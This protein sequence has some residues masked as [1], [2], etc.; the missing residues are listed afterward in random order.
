MQFLLYSPFLGVKSANSKKDPPHHGDTSWC[1][2]MYRDYRDVPWQCGG[3]RALEGVKAQSLRTNLLAQAM[4]AM[5]KREY[6][7]YKSAPIIR[8]ARMLATKSAPL[9]LRYEARR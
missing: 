2:V 8:R 4:R 3:S 7:C 9:P 1:I 5:R 6:T